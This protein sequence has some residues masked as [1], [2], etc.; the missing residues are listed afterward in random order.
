MIG[1]KLVRIDGN[2]DRRKR[3]VLCKQFDKHP[4]KRPLDTELRMPE[5][6]LEHMLELGDSIVECIGNHTEDCSY[7]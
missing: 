6:T 2:F 3:I 7:S 1:R 4:R 5:H